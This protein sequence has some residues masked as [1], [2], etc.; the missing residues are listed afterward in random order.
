MLDING[1]PMESVST[2]QS[3]SG[4]YQLKRN[5]NGRTVP[6]ESS[7]EKVI[8]DTGGV[9]VVE[10]LLKHYDPDGR[11]LPSERVRVEERK[12]SDGSIQTLTTVSRADVNGNYRVE[13]RSNAL[14][15]KSGDRT[16]TSTTTER[17]TIS[18]TLEMVERV[19]TQ[20]QSSGG[21]TTESTTR[22]KRDSNGRF[23]E[24]AKQTK[25]ITT[26]N[27]QTTENVAD[28]ENT[29]GNLR[30]VR[31]VTTQSSPGGTKEVSVF[32]PNN[33]GKM[34]VSYQQVIEKKPTTDGAVE[35]T[36]IRVAEPRDPGKLGPPRKA[37]EV[38]CTGECGTKK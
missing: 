20:S 15:K 28:Y 23:G 16:E 34:Q 35:T 4:S 17:P 32:T 10:R 21:K 14:T 26:S 11:A 5:L 30:M 31:Q 3:R 33:E 37:E 19:E 24:L 7:E 18:G 36:T 2:N 29:V 1:R 6:L 25:E 13:E 27:G 22:Y 38:I 8:S 12:Q 9:K